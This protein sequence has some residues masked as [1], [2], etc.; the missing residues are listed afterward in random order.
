MISA[1]ARMPAAFGAI[2]PAG[3][4]AT[5][6]RRT[7]KVRC[8][9]WRSLGP[10]ER[11]G[12][13][14]SIS[15]VLAYRIISLIDHRCSIRSSIIRPAGQT[16]AESNPDMSFTVD[17]ANGTVTETPSTP[18][19]SGSDLDAALLG[20]GAPEEPGSPTA[21][22]TTQTQSQQ[23]TPAQ[24][25]AQQQVQQRT[26]TALY[27]VIGGVLNTAGQTIG[28]IIASGNQVQIA[29]LTA[30]T[31]QR[32]AQLMSEAQQAQ[33]NGNLTLARQQAAQAQAAQQAMTQLGLTTQ[34][35]PTSNTG[36]YV[37]AGIVGLGVVGAVIYALSGRRRSGGVSRRS[38]R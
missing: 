20:G 4:I 13:A 5:A 33:A 24:Q 26:Q 19:I 32:I 31:N 29:Q 25:L 14:T 36:L 27:G 23:L 2:R 38:R 22:Q 28:Q 34:Q 9:E 12:I 17:E 18:A 8:G 1:V 35:Q 3:Q 15:P 7:F 16:Y 6:T 10:S 30:Q 21:T 11:L 37:V